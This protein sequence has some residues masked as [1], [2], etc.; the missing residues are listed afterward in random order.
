MNLLND[1]SPFWMPGAFTPPATTSTTTA[2]PQLP[3][4]IVVNVSGKHFPANKNVL[5]HQVRKN[6]V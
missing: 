1:P 5:A 6:S 3:I 2:S 4:D